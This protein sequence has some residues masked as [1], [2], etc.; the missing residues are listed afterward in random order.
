MSFSGHTD[1]KLTVSLLHNCNTKCSGAV[2]SLSL[3]P[4]YYSPISLNMC[5]CY[6]LAGPFSPREGGDYML[7]QRLIVKCQRWR[8][9]DG[10]QPAIKAE[11][12][13]SNVNLGLTPA[14]CFLHAIVLFPLCAAWFGLV[15]FYLRFEWFQTPTLPP[16]QILE[17]SS[18]RRKKNRL[19]CGKRINWLRIGGNQWI[20]KPL[21]RVPRSMY[22]GTASSWWRGLSQS[23]CADIKEKFFPSVDWDR[24]VSNKLAPIK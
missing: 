23:V 9:S 5:Y 3:S 18:V 24:Q 2:L 7:V 11:N 20:L 8:L 6:S 19:G 17:G 10:V 14:R 13:W 22:L 21:R 16:P 1:C 15:W 12:K 4:V